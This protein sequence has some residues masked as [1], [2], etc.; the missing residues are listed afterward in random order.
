[1][2]YTTFTRNRTN[3]ERKFLRFQ[4]HEV[5]EFINLIIP[6][7]RSIQLEWKTALINAHIR[8]LSS[9][10]GEK[11]NREIKFENDLKSVQ[12]CLILIIT[13]IKTV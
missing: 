10:P 4:V 13:Y 5:Y 11:R 2:L 1:M 7:V 9:V 8:L 6:L 3:S 12:S